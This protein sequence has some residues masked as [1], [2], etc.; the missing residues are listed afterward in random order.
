[1]M[2]VMLV[3]DH[4]VV[5]MGFRLLLQNTSDIEVI[6]EAESGEEAC[7]LYSEKHP[8]VVVMDLSMPGIGGLEAL[9]RIRARN[10]EARILVLSAHD[11]TMHPKRALEAG[12]AGYLSKRSAPEALIEALRQV[13]QGKIFLEPGIAQQLAVNQLTGQQNPVEVLSPREFEVFKLLAQGRSVNEIAD[14][15]FLSPRTVGTHLYNIKQKLNASNS[16]EIALIAM[17]AGVIQP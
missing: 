6:A 17:R 5:R 10:P 4:A 11:D 15:L 7:K 1:M 3:D 2:R 9:N 14:L 13:I 8:D 16:A 12:A